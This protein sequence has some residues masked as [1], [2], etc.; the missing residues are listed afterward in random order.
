MY[1]AGG[2]PELSPYMQNMTIVDNH[3]ATVVA[4][5]PGG[6]TMVSS[7]STTVECCG[8]TGAASAAP[9]PGVIT[10]A[11]KKDI[12][13]QSEKATG[14]GKLWRAMTKV[15][16]ITQAGQDR[17][18]VKLEKTRKW[19]VDSTTDASIFTKPPPFAYSVETIQ[20]L[21]GTTK[22]SEA[23]LE[24]LFYFYRELAL[25][26]ILAP[27]R[28]ALLL[29]PAAD[30]PMYADLQQ[31]AYSIFVDGSGKATHLSFISAVSALA[32][33]SPQE[34]FPLL[35]RLFGDGGYVHRNKVVELYMQI[36]RTHKHVEGQPDTISAALDQVFGDRPSLGL[37][38]F[39]ARC[40][41]ALTDEWWDAF[42]LFSG[43]VEQS[44]RK[45]E[46]KLHS[47]PEK[48]GFLLKEF[49]RV[50]MSSWAPHWCCLKE[51]FFI[52]YEKQLNIHSNKE[53]IDYNIWETSRKQENISRVVS[54]NVGIG[55]CSAKWSPTGKH[56][57]SFE[58]ATP[59]YRRKFAAATSE[60][61]KE[62]IKAINQHCINS[63]DQ[64]PFQ[65]T[66]PLHEKINARWL[67]DGK[68]TFKEMA[69]AIRNAKES[70]FIA[71]WFFSPEI[72]LIRENEITGATEMKEENRLDMMLQRKANEGVQICALIWNET[73][74]A[75]NLNSQ[76]AQQYLENLH[77][78]I[79]V[80]RHPLVAPV[81][82]SHHQKIL[83]VDQDYAFVG[84][85]DLAMGRWDDQCHRITDSQPPYRWNG[86]DYYN[87]L[88][89]GVNN[90][91]RP[92]VDY[93]DRTMNPRMA[94]HDVHTV[95]DGDAA[96]DVAANFIQRWNHHRE[97]IQGVTLPWLLPKAAVAPRT[98]SNVGYGTCEA[99]VL[100]STCEWSIGSGPHTETSIL[101]AYRYAIS[102]AEHFIYIEN[103]FFISST[104]GAPVEND[105]VA[106][107]FERIRKAVVNG[108]VFRVVV[109]L[110]VHP[111]GTYATSASVRNI[112][113]WN[114]HTITRGGTSILER[115]AKEFPDK[116]ASDYIVFCA[117][118]TYDFLARGTA[119]TEQIYIHSKLLIVD[120]RLVICGSANINDRSMLG[121]RDS[122]IC[123]MLNDTDFVDSRMNGAPY[124]KCRFA[125]DLR[126]SLWREHLGLFD[127]EMD[128]IDDP[129]CE[130]TFKGEWCARMN[131]NDKIYGEVFPVVAHD[132]IPCLLFLKD[133]SATINEQECHIKKSHL[134]TIRGHLTR[135]PLDFLKHE[136]LAP[137]RADIKNLDLL[138]TDEDVFT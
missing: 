6:G 105:I 1:G 55:Q 83:V 15:T 110:P 40:A 26:E 89:T 81:K 114:Y 31:R 71:D 133:W 20:P 52:Y 46:A 69:R 47:R 73:K 112:M 91:Q 99:Q 126:R 132:S 106:I 63:V 51:G 135:F 84:G 131:A 125:Y 65:S 87:P 21:L 3:N 111:D 120:D 124:K 22:F 92:D 24:Q 18:L 23:E 27:A 96:R 38:E 113:R 77:P 66:L 78:A 16:E 61:C 136:D 53:D 85:L 19:I 2:V 100:R 101:H 39:Q 102:N 72:Y 34:K 79:K 9:P 56:E 35:C 76:H 36:H 7:S 103:Q 4:P 107:I 128:N 82:W 97:V 88:V 12:V 32:R 127:H 80:I 117:L 130:A 94:W 93:F 64:F 25:S 29:P 90:V 62:W 43:I 118:R 10:P 109:I 37:D 137:N 95:V 74:V 41:G 122:E 8:P 17:A 50:G 68:D 86:K 58:V 5:T 134:M 129:V 115:F 138:F 14:M 48:E 119:V 116:T 67:V 33:G 98:H 54:L 104:G 13:N 121:K 59:H 75:V 60:E 42:G 49:V 11:P 30:Q 45:V 123:V 70:I 57:F 108:E 44:W 28:A